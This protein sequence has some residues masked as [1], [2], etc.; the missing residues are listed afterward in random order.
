M[1]SF[2]FAIDL[3]PKN[4]IKPDSSNE[5]V[6]EGLKNIDKITLPAIPEDECG[7]SIMLIY[8]DIYGNEFKEEFKLM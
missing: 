7:K 2:F 6:V 4:T 8:V 5:G 3:L 1:S